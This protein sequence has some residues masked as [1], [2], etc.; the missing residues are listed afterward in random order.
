MNLNDFDHTILNVIS[1]HLSNFPSL[2]MY[3]A[4]FDLLLICEEVINLE[5][6]QPINIL[7]NEEANEQEKQLAYKNTRLTSVLLKASYMI[8]DIFTCR[9]LGGLH[10]KKSMSMNNFI[11]SGDIRFSNLR[12]TSLLS[13]YC[14]AIYRNKLVT[15]HDFKRIGAY[16]TDINGVRRLAPLPESFKISIENITELESL[17]NKYQNEN[18]QLRELENPFVLLTNLFYSIPVGEIK[19]KNPDRTAIDK[20]AEI[21]GC[22]SLSAAEIINVIDEFCVE[23]VC[24]LENNSQAMTPANSLSTESKS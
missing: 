17:R 10:S 5:K 23:V 15:H 13:I 11:N 20:I 22:D 18:P 19:N 12:K 14:L 8:A 16:P 3:H 1:K 4:Y 9:L 2:D 7:F 21:G 24:C 6:Q